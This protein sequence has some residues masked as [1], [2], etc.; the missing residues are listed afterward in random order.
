MTTIRMKNT[1]LAAEVTGKLREFPKY[2]TQLINLANQNAQGTRPNVV[3]QMTELFREFGGRT[4]EEWSEWY[5]K[6]Q[7]DAIDD[8]TNRIFEM[9]KKLREAVDLIDRQMVHDWVE[10]LVL[11]KT[12]VGLSFQEAVLSRIA[13]IEGKKNRIST[14]AEESKGI[15]GYLDDIAVSIKPVTY[16]AKNMLR[17]NIEVEIIYYRKINNGI[18]FSYDFSN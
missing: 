12:F 15:D 5:L 10:D 9:I 11:A 13:S 1:E 3:G 18:E 8:A 16:D 7:P 2:T 17:E 4:Y 14:P 6:K